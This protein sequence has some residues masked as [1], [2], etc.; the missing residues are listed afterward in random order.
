MR[1]S[2][3]AHVRFSGE[4]QTIF[5]ELPDS[6]YLAWILMVLARHRIK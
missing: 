3:P 2:I 6:F 5:S 1:N 4:V